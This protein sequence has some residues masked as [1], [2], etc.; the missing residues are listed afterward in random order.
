VN[1][2][3]FSQFYFVYVLFLFALGDFGLKNIMLII[4]KI[5]TVIAIAIAVTLI[6]IA[7]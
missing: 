5:V 3:G 4:S 1:V 2:K 7:V 6:V